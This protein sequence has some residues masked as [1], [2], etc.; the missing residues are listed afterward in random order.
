MTPLY[1]G[2]HQSGIMRAAWL[3]MRDFDEIKYAPWDADWTCRETHSYEI[4][5]R[6]RRAQQCNF[7]LRVL[8]IK[9]NIYN[10]KYRFI[11]FVL[12][13]LDIYLSEVSI[14]F[15][16]LAMKKSNSCCV[17]KIFSD[18]LP[19]ECVGVDSRRETVKSCGACEFTSCDTITPL[20]A[21]CSAFV[22]PNIFPRARLS[23]GAIFLTSAWQSI[24][25]HCQVSRHF[26]ESWIF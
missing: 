18:S 8:Y 23:L 5:R 10:I 7:S 11:V 21:P 9:K 14:N 4:I 26:A 13:I 3:E 20:F 25:F 17:R 22:A 19:K 2:I 12:F 15:K 16:K 24:K 6:R 1:L